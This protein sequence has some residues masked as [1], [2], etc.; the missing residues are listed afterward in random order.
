MRAIFL[1]LLMGSLLMGLVSCKSEKPLADRGPELLRPQAQEGSIKVR[2]LFIEASTL[3]VQE[4]YEE[5]AS[6]FESVLNLD[7]DNHA[8][9]YNLARIAKAQQQP[10]EALT[11]IR[12][13]LRLSSETYWY[14]RLQKEVQL[15]LGEYK[16]AIQTQEALLERFPDKAEDRLELADLYAKN[17]QLEKSLTQLQEIEALKG[18]TELTSRNQYELLKKLKREEEALAVAR[19][20]IRLNPSQP[21]YYQLVYQSLIGMNRPDEAV[22]LLEGLLEEDPNNGFALLSLA[23]YYKRKDQLAKSDEYLFRAFANPEVSQ[24]GK[25][26]II[27]RLVTFVNDDASIR[28]RVEKLTQIYVETHPETAGGYSLQG[29][30]ALMKGQ[31]QD[32]RGLFR[33]GLDLEPS[34]L[35]GWVNLIQLSLMQQDTK[36][37]YDDSEEA[38]SYFPN[39]A[40]ILFYYGTSAA[41]LERTRSAKRALEK[42]IRVGTAPQPLTVQTHVE[43]ARIYHEEE[44]FASSDENLDAALTI[45]PDN[46]LI[47]NN[48]AY[49]LAERKERLDVAKEMVERALKI[50]PRQPSYLDT[51]GWI[52]YQQ[53]D[54]AA[55][56]KRFSQALQVAGDNAEILEHYGDALFKLGRTTEAKAQWEKALEAG[57]AFDLNTKMESGN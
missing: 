51:Y 43:L 2:Q 41:R 29:R 13:A 42:I 26:D 47:L 8:A 23:D 36:Q 54:Y 18:E 25:L 7:A 33:K 56:E 57:A 55:A 17:G 48:Y 11:H 9:H 49:Y 45:E 14:Y 6:S 28:S 40:Q 46:P 12:E 5:A 53:G 15:E 35:E 16:D 30:V 21:Y 22:E 19:T 3:L 34:N 52:L 10:N 38:M 24:E 1:P 50:E 27:N 31:I 4:K 32:A 20:L 44:D 39:Q 37:V